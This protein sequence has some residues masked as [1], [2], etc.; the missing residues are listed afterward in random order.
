MNDMNFRPIDVEF[1]CTCAKNSYCTTCKMRTGCRVRYNFY[2]GNYELVLEFAYVYCICKEKMTPISA[3]DAMK[4]MQKKREQEIII[5][6]TYSY[7]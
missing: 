7:M 5:H 3:F 1:L 4:K 6:K 2:Q